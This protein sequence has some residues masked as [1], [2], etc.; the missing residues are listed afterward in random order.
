MT[1][2]LCKNESLRGRSGSLRVSGVRGPKVRAPARDSSSNA[3]FHKLA[4]Q[5]RTGNVTVLF[6]GLNPRRYMRFKQADVRPAFTHSRG[7]RTPSEH[8]LLTRA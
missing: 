3:V 4:R 6:S 1:T 7:T 8:P 2:D 5:T